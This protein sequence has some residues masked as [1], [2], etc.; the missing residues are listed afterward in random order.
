LERLEK[1]FP[2]LHLGFFLYSNHGDY[3][4]R[5]KPHPK[6][7]ICIADISYS[8]MHGVVEGKSRSRNYYRH[9]L[10]QWGNLHK[11]QGNPLQLRGYNWN[12]ADN[13]LPYTKLKIWGEDLPFYH[14]LG[15]TGIWT[16]SIKAWS[17][18]GPSD[19]LEAQMLWNVN[20]NW[21]DILRHYC[22]KSFAAAAP[23]MEKYY[24][25]LAERQS[26]SGYE[27]GSYFAFPQIYNRTFVRKSEELFKDASAAVKDD[28]PAL[29]RVRIASI[30]IAS[31]HD[32]LDFRDAYS[33]CDFSKAET[34]FAEMKERLLSELKR[35]GMSVCRFATNRYPNLF[36]GKF[37]ELG[38]SCST[39]DNQI[40]YA[41]PDQLKAMIDPLDTGESFGYYSPAL[42]DDDYINVRTFGSTWDAQ[43]L[44]GMRRG[45]IWYR[46]KF[47]LP[48][49]FRGKKIGLF[50]G[51]GDLIFRAWN[52]GQKVGEGVG[53][54]K[55]FIFDLSNSVKFGEENVLAIKVARHGHSELGVGGLM[56]PSFVFA[57]KKIETSGES[58]QTDER[59]LP[60]GEREKAQKK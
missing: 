15:V 22:Q 9:I 7:S 5:Y 60:G 8:R 10:E 42:V 59:I 47:S 45:A 37:L 21:K 3:P 1:D 11:T 35:N 57:G 51:G 13:M 16:E 17:N 44:D 29:E 32:F 56:L 34:I 12:L 2:N 40:V 18:S 26:N 58:M 55:P 23:M 33:S 20:Q 41:F 25:D 28:A 46:V 38:K 6:I 4:V 50:L 53:Y 19:Y 27:A 14:R 48:E 39:G 43:G 31:L 30:P 54:L 49:H 52:N 24:L 36:F